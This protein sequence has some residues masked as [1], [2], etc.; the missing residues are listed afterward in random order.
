MAKLIAK[1]PEYATFP[2]FRELNIK[3]LLY[4]QVELDGLGQQLT[5][6]EQRDRRERGSPVHGEHYSKY[7]DTLIQSQEL[8]PGSQGRKQ[9]DLVIKIRECLRDYSNTH[10]YDLYL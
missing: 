5:E 6:I 7:A 8:A 3:N 1:V 4:Y 10:K 2:R 9:W